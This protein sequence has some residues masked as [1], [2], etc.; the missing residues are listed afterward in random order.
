MSDN[1]W[2]AIIG[3]CITLLV[4]VV[5]A[6]VALWVHRAG[7]R[8]RGREASIEQQRL[9]VVRML[10]T[11]EHTIRI[12]SAPSPLR[13]FRNPIAELTLAL[14]RLLL[15]LPA[16]DLAVAQWAAGQVQRASSTIRLRSFVNRVMN[17]EAKLISWHRGDVSTSWFVEQLRLEPY[18]PQFRA[19]ARVQAGVWLRDLCQSLTVGVA[20]GIGVKS[21]QS[22]IKS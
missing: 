9:M 7:E 22:L 5:A 17:I 21:L 20:I 3:G 18:D 15:E 14:P 19:P 4:G 8:A 10:D 16:S 12:R 1:L 2:A 13:L 11:I 6:A